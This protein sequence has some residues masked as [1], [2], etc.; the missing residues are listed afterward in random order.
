[1]FGLSLGVHFPHIASYWKCLP[2]AL[3]TSS[4]RA[5]AGYSFVDFYNLKMEAIRSSETSVHIRSTKCHV[6]KTAF[7]IVTA[8]RTPNPRI[9]DISVT[10]SIQRRFQQFASYVAIINARWICKSVEGSS[11]PLACSVPTSVSRN[12]RK[13]QKNLFGLSVSGSIFKRSYSRI[14]S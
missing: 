1:M 14:W 3:P 10:R 2:F 5:H 9:Y 13:Q 11:H 6:Q 7:F 12:S 4:P 8:V